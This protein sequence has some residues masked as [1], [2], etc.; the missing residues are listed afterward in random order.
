MLVEDKEGTSPRLQWL[1]FDTE[2]IEE[3]VPDMPLPTCSLI[4]DE[5]FS[6]RVT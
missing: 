3:G 1:D 6:N 4:Y 2:S 5:V